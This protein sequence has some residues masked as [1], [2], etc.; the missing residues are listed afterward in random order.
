MHDP[1]LLPQ[2]LQTHRDCRCLSNLNHKV[3]IRRV[4]IRKVHI[5]RVPIRK[6]HIRRVPIR[7]VP[8]R[9]V[10]IRKV[11]IRK[12]HIH[13]VHNNTTL[14]CKLSHRSSNLIINIRGTRLYMLS[15]ARPLKHTNKVG[16]RNK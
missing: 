7:K 5:R 11:H 2:L 6:V 8:I 12:V 9:R 3:H 16:K 4:P 1:K 13:K 14:G 10:P 15:T